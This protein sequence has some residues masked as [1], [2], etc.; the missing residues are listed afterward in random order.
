M[1]P[2]QPSFSN[3]KTSHNKDCVV[4]EKFGSFSLE[5]FRPLTSSSYSS[6]TFRQFEFVFFKIYFDSI[7]RISFTEFD[8]IFLRDE[9]WR[10]FVPF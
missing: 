10:K 1:N 9:E 7:F 2:D 5:T 4:T 6:E 8:G 3:R